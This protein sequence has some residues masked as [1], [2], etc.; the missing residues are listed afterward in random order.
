MEAREVT[1][2]LPTGL[3][4]EAE[5]CG[6]LTPESIE[7]LLRAEMERRERAEDVQ[8]ILQGIAEFDRG[9]GRPAREALEELRQKHGISC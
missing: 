6:L 7:A 4:L 3:A 1:I 5:A 2:N 8:A 9:E